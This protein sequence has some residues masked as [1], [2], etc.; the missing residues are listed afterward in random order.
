MRMSADDR[1]ELVLDAAQT[2]FAR[3]GYESTTTEAIANRVGV[4]QPYLF[5][6]FPS[7]KA[8]LVAALGR[9]F[10]RLEAI[11]EEAAKN[12]TGEAALVEMGQAYRK[13][14]G[15][16]VV[17]QMQLQMWALACG[18]TEIRDLARDRMERLWAQVKRLSGEDDTRVMQFMAGGMLLNVAAAMDLPQLTKQL[19]ESLAGLT[20]PGS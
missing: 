11:F 20:P 18:D 3:R 19:G 5:R 9:C 13:L 2:E 16:R 14:L 7:K 8:I 15:D 6:L 1:R 17:L 10:G 4:S 12:L